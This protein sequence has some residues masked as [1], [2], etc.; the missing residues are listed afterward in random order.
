M[1]LRRC[2]LS[3]ALVQVDANLLEDVVSDVV[4]GV[5]GDDH[6]AG[7]CLG[8]R[9]QAQAPHRGRS[10]CCGSASVQTALVP[11]MHTWRCEAW[12]LYVQRGH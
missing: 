1:T 11:G 12:S 2:V 5:V 8:G 4:G 9:G 6:V 3:H 7:D 10:W